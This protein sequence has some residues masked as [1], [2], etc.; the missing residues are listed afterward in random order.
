MNHFQLFRCQSTHVM[1]MLVGW[2]KHHMQMKKKC[3]EAVFPLY[4]YQV[5]EPLM[6]MSEAL[7]N[8]EWNARQGTP[9]VW[10]V[11]HIP[12]AFPNVLFTSG[13][14]KSV[15][16]ISIWSHIFYPVTM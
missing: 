10:E 7:C 4:V 15:I 12:T 11:Q 16:C 1:I 6:G 8:Q 13:A 5:A 9:K 3:L 14:N 2:Q